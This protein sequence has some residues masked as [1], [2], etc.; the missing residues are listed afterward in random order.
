[1]RITRHRIALSCH[2]WASLQEEDVDFSS[3]SRGEKTVVRAGGVLLVDLLFFPWHR[4]PG[5]VAFLG[6]SDPTRTA[7]QTPNSLQGTIAF[8]LTVAMVAQILMARSSST[9][10]NPT[11]IRLQ[12]VAGMAVLAVLAWKLA[13]DTGYLSVGAYLGIPLAAGVAYGGVLRGKEVGF[14]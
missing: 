14:K 7:V 10:P 13:I 8:L 2:R 4:F 11:L 5:A 12:P 1:M 3:L 9:R 6:V